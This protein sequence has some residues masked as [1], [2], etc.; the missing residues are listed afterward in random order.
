MTS[1][2]GSCLSVGIGMRCQR[3]ASADVPIFRKPSQSEFPCA[4]TSASS[5]P[6]NKIGVPGN[7]LADEDVVSPLNFQNPALVDEFAAVGLDC[8]ISSV[9]KILDPS[10]FESIVNSSGKD[11]EGYKGNKEEL[12]S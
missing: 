12:F 7:K 5:S 4:T 11:R 9:V 3:A 2:I 8:N 6:L 10:P 1:S